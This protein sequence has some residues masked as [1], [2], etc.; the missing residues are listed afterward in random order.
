MIDFFALFFFV[1]ATARLHATYSV[2]QAEFRTHQKSPWF[3][4]SLWLTPLAPVWLWKVAPHVGI[5]PAVLGALAGV[6]VLWWQTH[7]LY[8]YFHAKDEPQTRGV[9]HWLSRVEWLSYVASGY[10]LLRFGTTFLWL[11]WLGEM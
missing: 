3:P 5:V 2:H 4:Y 6:C 7:K 11:H 9:L 8:H 1:F 10:V